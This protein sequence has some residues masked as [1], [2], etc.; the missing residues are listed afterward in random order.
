MSLES[1]K[2]QL[3]RLLVRP[4]E[5]G[6]TE[7]DALA[8]YLP[9]DEAQIRISVIPGLSMVFGY[10]LYPRFL[11]KKRYIYSGGYCICGFLSF[12]K[13][14]TILATISSKDFSNTFSLLPSN[15]F[16]MYIESLHIN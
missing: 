16:Y 8:I 2:K 6:T 14:G 9:R 15:S 1:A 4:P 13:L 10:S 5:S 12:I 7:Q 11:A 3:L